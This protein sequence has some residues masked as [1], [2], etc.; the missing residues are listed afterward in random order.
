MVFAWKR[1][2]YHTFENSKSFGG[3]EAG[4]QGDGVRTRVWQE[5]GQKFSFALDYKALNLVC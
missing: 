3:D 1:T 2:E 4:I 5:T